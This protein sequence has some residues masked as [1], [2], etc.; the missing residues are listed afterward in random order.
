MNLFTSFC[1][2]YVLQRSTR[3]IWCIFKNIVFYRS[4]HFKQPNFLNM[5]TIGPKKHENVFSLFVCVFCKMMEVP[6]KSSPHRAFI[7]NG[8]LRRSSLDVFGNLKIWKQKIVGNLNIL[9]RAL[10]TINRQNKTHDGTFLNNFDSS[11][12]QNNRLLQ[13]L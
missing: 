2:V 9:K 12:V 1:Y 8:I 13:G 4:Q 3:N 5:E 6:N 10:L 7:E 11:R